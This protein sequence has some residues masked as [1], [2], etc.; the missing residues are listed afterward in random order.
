MTDVNPETIL[1]PS[2]AHRYRLCFLSSVLL[3]LASGCGVQEYEKKML[4]SQMRFQRWEEE[5][6]ILG[7][8][9]QTPYRVVKN[10]GP[11]GGESEEA[12]AN[13]FIRL[14]KNIYTQSE[15]DPIGPTKN[16]YVFTES[17]AGPVFRVGLAAG[18]EKTFVDDIVRNFPTDGQPKFKEINIRGS[19]REV[20]TKFESTELRDE[21][22]VYLVNIWTGSTKVAIVYWIRRGNTENQG[23]KLAED[24]LKT[25]AGGKDATEQRDL[26]KKGSPAERVPDI[27]PPSQ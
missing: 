20:P 17:T 11:E 19:G 26:Y 27:P 25:F 13:I 2:S 3:A 1:M 15:K 7:G 8:P 10:T 23:K 24:S 18:D 6:K 5:G 4:D 12:I 14:P 16:L 9:A 21:K 22:F